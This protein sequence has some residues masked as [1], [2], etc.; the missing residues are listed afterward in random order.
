MSGSARRCVLLSVW[1]VGIG[2]GTLLGCQTAEAASARPAALQGGKSSVAATPLLTPHSAFEREQA[3]TPA[4]LVKRWQ[5]MVV[6]ASR[7]FDIPVTWIN[8]VIRVESG[9][10]T[11]LSEKM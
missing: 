8:A 5:P 1:A 10:R 11:M 6:K 2:L 3:L 4:Q 7:R 9:G